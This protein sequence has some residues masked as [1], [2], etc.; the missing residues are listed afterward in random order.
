MSVPSRETKV[1][2][3]LLMSMSICAAL[4]LALGK[5]P[6]SAGAFCL[7]DYY[8][9]DPVEKNVS[10]KIEQFSDRWNAIEIF[11]NCHKSDYIKKTNQENEL[12]NHINDDYHFA[13]C[14]GLN[15]GDGIIITTEK[16]QIQQSAIH[17]TNKIS[18]EKTI[19]ICIIKKNN[20]AEQSEYQE[21]RLEEL[22]EELS[23]RFNISPKEVYYP[24]RWR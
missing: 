22:I 23:R 1:F 5:N 12:Q 19:R 3:V 7:D 2:A 16:W 14:N 4:L 13:L 20:L 17:Y 15:G 11:Y 24:E 18:N 8:R 21:K 10:S 6:P 9:L